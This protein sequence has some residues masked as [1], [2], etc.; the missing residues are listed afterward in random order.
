MGVEIHA[1]EPRLYV[2]T[3]Y[4]SCTDTIHQHSR[5]RK[6]LTG[7]RSPLEWWCRPMSLAVDQGRGQAVTLPQSKVGADRGVREMGAWDDGPKGFAIGA[8]RAAQVAGTVQRDSI[9][10][11]D[12]AP[13]GLADI[14]SWTGRR[15]ADVGLGPVN[16]RRQQHRFAATG[17]HEREPKVVGCEVRRT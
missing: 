7:S 16:D 12:R 2:H 14:G 6:T 10:K 11:Q 4:K 17:I 8:Q 15:R 9:G 1:G 3:L 13:G 5:K